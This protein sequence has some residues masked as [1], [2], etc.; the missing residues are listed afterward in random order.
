MKH[1]AI[2]QFDTSMIEGDKCL[3]TWQLNQVIISHQVIIN[4]W[5]CFGEYNNLSWFY[6]LS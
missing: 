3:G 4:N 2:S 1:L 6:P 5:W